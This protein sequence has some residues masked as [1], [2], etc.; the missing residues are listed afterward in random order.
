LNRMIK[1]LFIAALIIGNGLAAQA[2]AVGACLATEGGFGGTGHESSRGKLSEGGLGGT[3]H[4]AAPTRPINQSASTEGGLGGTGLIGVI[5]GF[6]SICVDGHDIELDKETRVIAQN[7]SATG[8]K[9]ALGQTVEVIASPKRGRLTAQTVSIT[10]TLSGPATEYRKDD[11]TLYVL[12][13][14]VDTSESVLVG[15]NLLD[16]LASGNV[17]ANISGQW[18]VD[19]VLAATRIELVKSRRANSASIS[20]PV[21]MTDNNQLRIGNVN[22]VIPRAARLQSGSSVRIRGEW[23]NGKLYAKRVQPI[24]PLLLASNAKHIVWEGYLRVTQ[25]G[26]R[27]APFILRI[28]P[29]TRI[30]RI[31]R[32]S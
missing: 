23:R 6:G 24:K 31:A 32:I 28:D 17:R 12:G 30:D 18:R 7:D 10:R 14:P 21:A 25:E 22:I 13:Q 5:T 26:Y 20:G 19:G 8:A 27:A 11:Q 4:E 16:S 3:G 9:L 29:G 1:R 15:A 2:Y